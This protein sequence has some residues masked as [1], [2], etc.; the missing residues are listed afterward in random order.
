M[1]VQAGQLLINRR[2]L[3]LSAGAN[4]ID[5]G[6]RQTNLNFDP[7]PPLGGSVSVASR[8][9]VVPLPPTNAWAGVSISEPVLGAG[10]TVEVT[11]NAPDPVVLNVMFWDP[12]TF[13]CPMNAE[14]YGDCDN[15]SEIALV[16]TSCDVHIVQI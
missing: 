10:G 6:L 11:F 3:S 4:V 2:R 1:A 8:V 5:T 16:E 12:H 7:D 13:I 9:M 15:Y 14:P